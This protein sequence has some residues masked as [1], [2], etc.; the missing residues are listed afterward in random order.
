[1]NTPPKYIV[2]TEHA[3]NK[4][5]DDFL[6]D[7]AA[8]AARK[9]EEM[10][11]SNEGVEMYVYELRKATKA[12]VERKIVLTDRPIPEAVVFEEQ[13]RDQLA[14]PVDIDGGK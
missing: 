13:V 11:A 9:A 14:T 7:E 12:T 5:N 4:M 8:S 2:L 3:L 6:L 1:M 10:A